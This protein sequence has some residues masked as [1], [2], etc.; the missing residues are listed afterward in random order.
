MPNMID[1][2]SLVT[3]RL[4]FF[5]RETELGSGTGFFTKYQGKVFL[6]TNWHNVTGRNTETLQPISERGGIPDRM[7]IL[8]G[9]RGH[10][11]E[12]GELEIPLYKDMHEN[13]PPEAPV[14][15]E[16]AVPRR[17]QI[18]VVA[19][20]IDV[21]DWAEVRT[22]DTVNTAP[23]ML[24]RVSTDVFVL[25]YPR[26]ISGGRGFPIWKRASIATEPDID[27]DGPKMLI[28]TATREGM[29]GGPVIAVAHRGFEVK[30]NMFIATSDHGYRFVGVYSGRLGSDEMKAQLGIVWKARVVDEILQVPIAGTSSFFMPEA[31]TDI[32]AR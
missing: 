20:P 12:W 14:W 8:I 18:D 25:G 11:G 4:R 23:K 31:T 2:G 26:E 9:C 3:S 5:Y 16:H 27:L 28:D 21:P 29:S 7:K 17:P 13:D 19:I 10:V 30:S 1:P 24:L 6:I 22:S 15:L 32:D